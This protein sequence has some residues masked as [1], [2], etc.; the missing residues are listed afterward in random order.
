MK[1]NINLEVSDAQRN[2]LAQ[3]LDGKPVKRLA[4][5]DDVRETI[6]KFVTSWA[7][8]PVS[9]PPE[10]A[11]ERGVQLPASAREIEARLHE[12]GRSEA[13]IQSYLRGYLGKN[14][15]EE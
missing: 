14:R 9:P 12:E 3:L 7:E 10:K 4:T 13:Y 2:W 15:R 1:V 8:A 11:A 6:V 5:R